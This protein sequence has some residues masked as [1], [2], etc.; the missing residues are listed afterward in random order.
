MKKKKK[1]GMVMEL[2]F[3]LGIFS[4]ARCPAAGSSG[5]RGCQVLP[6]VHPIMGMWC[7]SAMC[8]RPCASRSP[9]GVG[10]LQGMEP[11]QEHHTYFKDLWSPSKPEG[12]VQLSLPGWA[13]VTRCR[14]A[15]VSLFLR[16]ILQSQHSRDPGGAVEVTLM[17]LPLVSC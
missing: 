17:H 1:A 5:G 11:I 7:H 8:W 10:E 15:L 9:A 6:G 14:N 12:V 4:L 13:G 2:S 16:L 3:V